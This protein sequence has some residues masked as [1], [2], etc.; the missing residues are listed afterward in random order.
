M[1]VFQSMLIPNKLRHL[2]YGKTN[3]LFLQLFRY[4]FVGCLAFIVDFG[5]LFLF[6]DFVGMHYLLSASLSFVAG[7]LVNYIIS[8]LWVFDKT[9][10]KNGKLEFLV[11]ALIGVIGLGL[12]ELLMWFFTD[13]LGLF[14]MLSKV[15]T[16]AIVYF[17][18]FF[19]RKY[20]IFK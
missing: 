2:V 4:T 14:Y 17:W 11:F 10:I 15:L 13:V 12:T 5:L 19:A 16:T 18:N 20:M 1:H 8:K 9:S 7:L 3:N 6:T